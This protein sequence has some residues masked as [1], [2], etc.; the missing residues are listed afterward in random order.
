MSMSRF[1]S[2]C[3]GA[4][5]GDEALQGRR[6]AALVVER[7]FEEF[8]ERVVGLRPE[9]REERVRPPLGAE[10]ARVERERRLA[11]RPARR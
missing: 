1:T 10:H 11:P 7:E 9:P 6:L 4:Q 8:V 5:P 3:A 2:V